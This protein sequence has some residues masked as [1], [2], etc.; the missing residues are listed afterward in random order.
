MGRNEERGKA[1]ARGKSEVQ[2]MG[3]AAERDWTT[4]TWYGAA[5]ISLFIGLRSLR[6][7]EGRLLLPRQNN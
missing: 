7:W 3:V 1:P 2:E 4:I 6:N 5:N